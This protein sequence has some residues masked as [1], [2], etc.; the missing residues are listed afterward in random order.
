MQ[1]EI[2]VVVIL[3]IGICTAIMEVRAKRTASKNAEIEH[4]SA[5]EASKK[6]DEQI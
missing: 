5:E 3:V 4:H 2:L 1:W 6:Q